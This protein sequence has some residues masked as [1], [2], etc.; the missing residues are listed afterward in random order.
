MDMYI[1]IYIN[2]KWT[3]WNTR[4]SY[5]NIFLILLFIWSTVDIVFDKY[6]EMFC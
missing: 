2:L 1:F 5:V 4:F 6:I 3:D